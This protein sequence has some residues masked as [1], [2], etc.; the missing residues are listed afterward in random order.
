MCAWIASCERSPRVAR[1]STTD[2]SVTSTSTGEHVRRYANTVRR[3]SGC[4]SW[5]RKPARRWWRTSAAT[6]ARSR[7]LARSR[8]EHLPCELRSQSIVPHERHA[9]VLRA[10]LAC[11]RLGGVVQQ[12]SPAQRLTAGHLIRERLHKQMRHALVVRADGNPQ[13]VAVVSATGATV[14]DARGGRRGQL[15]GSLEHLQRVVVHVQVVEAALLDAAQRVELWQY[16]GGGPDCDCHLDPLAGIRGGEYPAQLD[17]HPLAR[18]LTQ[19][20][21]LGGGAAQ[22]ILVGLHLE[23]DGDPHEAQ[24]PQRIV[25]ERVGPGHPQPAGAQVGDAAQRVDRRSAVLELS[26]DCVDGEVAQSE[27]RLDRLSAQRLYIHLPGAIARHHPP[28]PELLRQGKASRASAGARDR[29]GGLRGIPRYDDV[30]V[31]CLAT[32]QLVANGSSDEPRLRACESRAGGV[33]A[34]THRGC[35]PAVSALTAPLCCRSARRRD[36]RSVARAE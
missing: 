19:A 32:K 7:S 2:S 18:H 31:R 22:G 30:E 29:S 11:G 26:C 9:P 35:V 5:T 1:R 3:D 24:D 28:G 8:V 14:V 27:V 10:N 4:G 23:L 16:G 36:G 13:I 20:V 34:R 25:R 12:R 21:R 33:Q 17:E 15:D 6:C